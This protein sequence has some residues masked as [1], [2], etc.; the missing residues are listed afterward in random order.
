MFYCN[1]T[2]NYTKKEKTMKDF[3]LI[4]LN[5]NKNNLTKYTQKLKIFRF[6]NFKNNLTIIHSFLL[7]RARVMNYVTI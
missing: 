6:D 1:L 5:I 2:K 3:C 4:S 7:I